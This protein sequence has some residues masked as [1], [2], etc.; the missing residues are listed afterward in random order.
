MKKRRLV[1]VAF[2]LIAAIALGVGYATLSTTL[3]ID[4]VA[5]IKT[6]GAKTEYDED[7][8]FKSGTANAT[9]IDGVT[10]PTGGKTATV[11]IDSLK[12]E[13]NTAT[14]TFVVESTSQFETRVAI[15]DIKVAN[16][17]ANPSTTGLVTTATANDWLDITAEWSDD[18]IAPGNVTPAT[19][20]LTLTVR[21]KQTPTEAVNRTLM[22]EIGA[23]TTT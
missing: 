19:T 3:V 8:Y 1:I 22:V 15:D 6:D 16:V 18:T 14:F 10:I 17:T 23:D 11:T 5:A 2:L 13:G 20:T 4:G 21:L 12:L 9:G 7:V